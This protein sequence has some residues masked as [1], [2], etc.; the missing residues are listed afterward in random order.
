MWRLSL[1]MTGLTLDTTFS[2]YAPSFSSNSACVR[3][4]CFCVSSSVR[5]HS[6][7][8]PTVMRFSCSVWLETGLNR[9]PALMEMLTLIGIVYLRALFCSRWPV[10]GLPPLRGTAVYRYSRA[11][12]HG[13]GRRGTQAAFFLNSAIPR[14]WSSA[15]PRNPPIRHPWNAP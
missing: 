6:L 2:Q 3:D 8:R 5:V 14:P 13:G 12:A 15:Q 9:P 1:T 11:I 10:E 4:T 7:S